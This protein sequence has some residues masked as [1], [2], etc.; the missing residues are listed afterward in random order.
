VT[1]SDGPS[2]LKA[3]PVAPPEPVQPGVIV[4]P[5]TTPFR[6]PG[7]VAEPKASAPREMK[8]IPTYTPPPAR[9]RMEEPIEETVGDRA[10]EHLGME[11]GKYGAWLYVVLA[12]LLEV[13]VLG[14]LP[15]AGLRYISED[16]GTYAGGAMGLVAA[17]FIFRN[18]WRCIE[19]FSSRFCSGL[20]NLSILYVPLVA[21]VYA[22]IR[23][24]KKVSG[25]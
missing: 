20:M 13:V 12:F 7:V 22:N 14:A 25:S 8:N 23:G 9:N 6:E 18:R 15:A 19:A 2:F 21:F 17:Y 3:A 10:G 5:P 11:R 1:E 4:R 16:F 24:I